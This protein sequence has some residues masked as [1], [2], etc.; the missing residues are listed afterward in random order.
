MSP[1]RRCQTVQP[2]PGKHGNII[3]LF[4]NPFHGAIFVGGEREEQPSHLTFVVN[5]PLSPS[6]VRNRAP[7]FAGSPIW[8]AL[9][10]HVL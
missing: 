10:I 4:F 1:Y 5:S 7:L 9:S 3:D 8:L 6:T 2:T